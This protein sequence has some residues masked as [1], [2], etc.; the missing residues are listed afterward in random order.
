MKRCFC[1]KAKIIKDNNYIHCRYSI[2]SSEALQ[3]AED[4]GKKVSFYWDFEKIWRVEQW[5]FFKRIP[6]W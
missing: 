6:S 3:M 1:K 4:N 5:E 2:C